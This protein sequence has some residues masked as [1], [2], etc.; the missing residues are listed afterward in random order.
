MMK[1][2]H[3]LMAC[4]VAF[5]WGSTF[6]AIHIGFMYFPP[7]LFVAL[8]FIVAAFPLVFF[9]RR[10]QM[11]WR[12]IIAYGL[13]LGVFLYGLWY[14]G[15]YAGVA[16]GIASLLLQTQVIFTALIAAIIMRDPPTIW[17]KA[18]IVLAFVGIGIIGSEMVHSGTLTGLLCI[19]SAAFFWGILNMVM[20]KAGAMNQFHL[21]VYASLVPPVPLLLLSYV[22]EHNQV[23]AITNIT[24]QGIG[25][26]AYTAIFGTVIAF[27][28]WGK[29]LR[30]Y[31]PNIVAPFSLL[32]PLF[33]MS[34]STLILGETFSGLKVL[35]S[36]LVF[37]GLAMSILGPQIVV[38]TNRRKNEYTCKSH[39]NQYPE[40]QINKGKRPACLPYCVHD[41]NGKADGLV[42]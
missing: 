12:W 31:S 26:L 7:I 8:R 18:G 35:G 41:P 37:F 30:I 5:F 22:F 6:V 14:V 38:I 13:L 25:I 29:L 42:C 1:L 28:I 21:V 24:W 10:G 2:P 17:Q 20:K 27:A 36:S 3:I 40:D 19:L 23:E 11:L 15:M 33:G 39:K 16:A 34:L 4:L 32:V 9:I